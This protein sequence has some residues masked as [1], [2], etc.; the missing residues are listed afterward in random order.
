MT[1]YQKVLSVFSFIMSSIKGKVSNSEFAPTFRASDLY[2]NGALVIKDGVLYRCISD[3]RGEWDGSHFSHTMM[4]MNIPSKTSEIAN[5]EGFV[6]ASALANALEGIDVGNEA[7]Q[8]DVREALQGVL[9][10]LKS[11]GKA[12]ILFIAFISYAS[13]GGLTDDT[14][15]EEVVPT[16]KVKDVVEK[17]S[18]PADFSENNQELV[19]TIRKMSVPPDRKYAMFIIPLNNSFDSGNGDKAFEA[20]TGFELKGSTNNFSA[21]STDKYQ[22]YGSSYCASTGDA[23]KGIGKMRMYICSPDQG[24]YDPRTYRKVVNTIQSMDVVTEIVVIIDR[25]C[26]IEPEGGAWMREDNEEL[27]WVFNKS[28]NQYIETASGGTYPLWRPISPVRWLSN[29]PEWAKQ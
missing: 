2:E 27:I 28:S 26:L 22:F 3:H 8:K 25:S 6:S 24:N 5:D 1:I 21:T 13:I 18:P 23:E 10:A 14:K 19:G 7:T 11:I 20:F 29:L 4:S 16:N 12:T 15:W 9:T 17:F